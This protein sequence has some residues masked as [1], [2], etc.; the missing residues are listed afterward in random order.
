MTVAEAVAFVRVLAKHNGIAFDVPNDSRVWL[1]LHE[2]ASMNLTRGQINAYLAELGGRREA[3]TPL[4]KAGEHWPAPPKA[5]RRKGRP[6][7]RKLPTT[8]DEYERQ[9]E[10]QRTSAARK[11]RAENRKSPRWKK[12]R[13]AR[14]SLAGG[15]CEHCQ[16]KSRK[17]LQLHHIHYETHGFER[18][19]D[20]RAL[21]DSCH[22]KETERQRAQRRA[23]WKRQSGKRLR[24]FS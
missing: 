12:L 9:E 5:S 15:R 2:F 11:A 3:G 24:R 23:Q 22:E 6:P 7:R 4:V 18:L 16:Q 10:Q 19:E 21:C 1:R 20:V 17:P 8:L 14:I 13:E